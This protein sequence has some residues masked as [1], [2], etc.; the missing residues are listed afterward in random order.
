[1]WGVVQMKLTIGMAAYEDMDGVYFTVQSLRSYHDLKD[2]EIIV[3]DNK[4]SDNLFKWIKAWGDNTVRYCRFTDIQGTA[5]PRHHVF[6]EAKGEFVI[7]VD[8]HVLLLPGSL[9]KLWDG[10]DLIHGPMVYDNIRY[11]CVGMENV[12]RDNMWGIWSDPIRITNLQ[13][14][15]FEIWGHGLGL[16]G[17]RKDSWLGFNSN[18]RQFGGEE[19]Y[20]HEKYRKAGRRV[21]CLPWL[22][23]VHRFEDLRDNKS[24]YPKSIIHRVRNYLIG[25]DELDLDKQPIVDH[26]GIQ[27]VNKA[28]EK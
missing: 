11:C 15:Q 16:F 14:N 20:I 17:C 5:A 2:C 3:V 22:Q 4:G 12:W 19:G 23:W 27:L 24:N 7:C 26:F 25:F 10:E 8:P 28:N 21:L 13:P 18:F 6:E 1:M 9:D